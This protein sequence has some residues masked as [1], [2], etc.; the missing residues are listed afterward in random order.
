MTKSL[1]DA[2]KCSIATWGK[3]LDD[4]ANPV[5]GD[6]AVR[7]RT[8]PS[9]FVRSSVPVSA[10]SFH[11]GLAEESQSWNTVLSTR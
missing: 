10:K 9:G 6:R 5:L 8:S 3:D 11:F 7:I 2:P 1:Y 4:S